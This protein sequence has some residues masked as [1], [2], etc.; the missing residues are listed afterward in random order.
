MSPLKCSQ[1]Y[2]QNKVSVSFENSSLE[3]WKCKISVKT[4]KPFGCTKQFC[5]LQLP[6]SYCVSL[7]MISITRH[8]F[9]DIIP[10]GTLFSWKICHGFWDE[11]ELFF[12][13]TKISKS[14]KSRKNRTWLLLNGCSFLKVALHVHIWNQKVELLLD[15]N[16]Q[17]NNN[18]IKT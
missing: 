10:N 17:N 13:D 4:V 9:I 12:C 11:N 2:F 18:K 14:L 6:I 8:V 5:I 7:I 1:P 15:I 16:S 3:R